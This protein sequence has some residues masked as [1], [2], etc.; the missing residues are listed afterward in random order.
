M[1]SYLRRKPCKTV[2]KIALVGDGHTGKSSFFEYIKSNRHPD[3]RFNKNYNA[4][5]GCKVAR[6]Q[7]TVNERDV[8][9]YLFDTAGQELYGELREGYLL[10]IDGAIVMYDLTDDN[11]KINVQKWLNDI[12]GLTI[13]TLNE[14]SIPVLVC[15]N[16]SDLVVSSPN[17]GVKRSR[18]GEKIEDPMVYNQATLQCMYPNGFIDFRKISVKEGEKVREAFDLMI[19]KVFGCWIKP[20]VVQKSC[21]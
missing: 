15:G 16:K 19:K 5:D 18:M 10:G 4:T 2:V 3:Y 13:K 21:T 20:Q 8:D 7:T 6:L 12:K 14:K 1:L 11:S 9:I 17:R